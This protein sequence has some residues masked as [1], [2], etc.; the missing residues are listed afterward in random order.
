MAEILNDTLAAGATSASL[1]VAPLAP[2]AFNSSAPCEVLARNAASSG[3]SWGLL[4]KCTSADDTRI[5][6]PTSNTIRVKAG[7]A[8]ARVL[9]IDG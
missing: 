8:A 5:L 9:I 3:E 2:L 7:A 4:Y 6:Y 1:T